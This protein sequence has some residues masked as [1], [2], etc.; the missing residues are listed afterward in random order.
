M[1]RRALLIVGL[2]AAPLWAGADGYDP[3]IEARRQAAASALLAQAPALTEALAAA[4]ARAERGYPIPCE[5]GI[6]TCG[7]GM[8]EIISLPGQWVGADVAALAGM[9]RL[10][11]P[12][13]LDQAAQIAPA[14]PQ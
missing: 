7:P 10:L 11:L 1:I 14:G 9:V 8:V 6:I 3:A 4:E 5:A 2:I 13:A 12:L